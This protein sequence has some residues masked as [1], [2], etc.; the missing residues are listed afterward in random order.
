MD[1]RTHRFYDTH[2]A[3]VAA[4]YESAGGGLSELFSVLFRAGQSVLD[5]GA[6]SGRD[7]DR[8]QALGVDAWGL[9]P[10]DELRTEA[11]RYHPELK[12]RLIA[13][14]LPSDPGALEGRTFDGVILSAVIMHIP[15]ADL[16]DFAVAVRALLKRH[17]RLVVSTSTERDDVNQTTSRDA[18]GRLYR[19]RGAD[20]VQRLFTRVGFRLES[21]CVSEDGLGRPGMKWATLVF[22]VRGSAARA[23]H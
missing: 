9:E 21:R 4:R 19:L 16:L 5:I 12:D 7:M 3:E 2:S 8:L 15:D 17:G 23:R 6:G 18:G 20:E 1:D 13:G 22:C 10:S 11:I 14:A